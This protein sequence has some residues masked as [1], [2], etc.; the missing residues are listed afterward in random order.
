MQN[1]F[2]CSFLED[3]FI[4]NFIKIVQHFLIKR[5][6]ENTTKSLLSTQTCFGKSL[7]EPRGFVKYSIWCARMRWNS[8]NPFCANE[9]KLNVC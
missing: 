7:A 8:C 5:R 1:N 2:H 4:Y 6:V 9:E 3:I